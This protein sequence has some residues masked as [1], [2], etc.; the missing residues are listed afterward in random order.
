MNG[1][2]YFDAASIWIRISFA[3]HYS[4]HDRYS[5]LAEPFHKTYCV[6][7]HKAI[8]HGIALA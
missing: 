3:V 6:E 4:H 8:S 1:C 5:E 2:I 7:S